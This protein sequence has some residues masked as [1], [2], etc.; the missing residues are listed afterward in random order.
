MNTYEEL[1][2]NTLDGCVLSAMAWV[3]VLTFFNTY[4]KKQNNK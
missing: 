2:A 1:Q 4:I 3:C